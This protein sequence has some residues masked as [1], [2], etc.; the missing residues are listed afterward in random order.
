[1][2]RRTET[3]ASGEYRFDSLPTGVY[4]VEFA[5]A[6]HRAYG[7]TEE[8]RVESKG[9]ARRDVG[10]SVERRVEGYVRFEGKPMADI[11]VQMELDDDK[12]PSID[13]P[14][15]RGSSDASGHYEIDG[16]APGNY[17]LGV[18]ISTVP[19]KD[20]PY[21]PTYYPGTPDAKRAT[22]VSFTVASMV[23]RVDVELPAPLKLVTIRG[24]VAMADGTPP[25]DHLTIAIRGAGRFDRIYAQPEVAP[26]GTFTYQVCEGVHYRIHGRWFSLANHDGSFSAPVEFIAQSNI[27]PFNLKLN[28]NSEQ[29]YKLDAAMD[30]HFG[31]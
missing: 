12:V 29:F 19:S 10:F 18:N 22:P 20:S 17:R 9:C 31:K 8:V 28:L 1:V 6:G 5:L 26:D 27:E 21:K 11:E 16:I 15:F 4:R 3:N 13:K 25:K 23:K 2:D 14:I 7:N 30:T 24:R